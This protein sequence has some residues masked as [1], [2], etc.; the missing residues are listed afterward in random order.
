MVWIEFMLHDVACF[1]YF[2]SLLVTFLCVI[3][4]L[5]SVSDDLWAVDKSHNLLMHR[6]LSVKLSKPTPT[7][8]GAPS[9]TSDGDWEIV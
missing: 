2:V 4:F 6:Q 3:L 9:F 1:D 5:A 7:S 8:G